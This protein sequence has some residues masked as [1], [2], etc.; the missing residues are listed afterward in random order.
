M[1]ER[2][3]IFRGECPLCGR[4]AVKRTNKQT[5]E[6]FFGCSGF[7]ECRWS[8]DWEHWVEDCDEHPEKWRHLRFQ[9]EAEMEAKLLSR[10]D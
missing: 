4:K 2:Y 10:K 8:E 7:P 5:G 9:A 3:G 6:F 1:S